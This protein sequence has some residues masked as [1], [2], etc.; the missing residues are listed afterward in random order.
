MASKFAEVEARYG[1]P[2][3]EIL[4]DLF[5]KHGSLT[6]IAKELAVTQSTISLW[7]IKVG[8]RLEQR[9]HLVKAKGGDDQAES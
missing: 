9:T 1:R 7:L 3:Q 5:A 8:L 2:M 4:L 6:G